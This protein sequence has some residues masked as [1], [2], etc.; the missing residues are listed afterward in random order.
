MRSALVALFLLGALPAAADTAEAISDHV[1]PGYAE[2]A[3]ASTDL[4]GAAAQDCSAA[5]LKEP[6]NR[7]F[8]A[9]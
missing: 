3:R 5:P 4:A 2:F 1:L 6:W 9:W 7:A 8:D